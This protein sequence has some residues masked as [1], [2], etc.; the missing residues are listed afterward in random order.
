MSS[1]FKKMNKPRHK[2]A[3]LAYYLFFTASHYVFPRCLIFF[4]IYILS[5]IEH[6]T[7]Y[8]VTIYKSKSDDS[9]G[10]FYFF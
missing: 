2:C 9:S 1:A 5:P 7:N 10:V 6:P 4:F 8:P 3:Q